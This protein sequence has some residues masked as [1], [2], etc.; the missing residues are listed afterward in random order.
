MTPQ[1]KPKKTYA[2]P[3]YKMLDANTAK[4][5]PE[6]R[7][8]PGEAGARAM[9]ELI[10]KSTMKP[11]SH[12]SGDVIVIRCP[13]RLVIREETFRKE[14]KELISEKR[15]IILDLSE[16]DH[17]DSIGLAGLVGV[18]T[19][20]SSEKREIRLVYAGGHLTDL[21]RR[22]RLDK[23]LKVYTS[24]EDAIASFSGTEILSAKPQP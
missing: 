13:G 11:G 7:A 10:C 5:A 9:M 18:F 19:W 17:I 12:I 20:A 4:A 8:V 23:I 16:T 14:V 15:R 2:A 21:L 22:T 24:E 6:T 1:A 3:S